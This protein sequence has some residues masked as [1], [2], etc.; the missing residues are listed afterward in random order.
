MHPSLT[1]PAIAT[2][3]ANFYGD[4]QRDPRLNPIFSATLGAHWQKHM[5]RLTDFWCTVMLG[6][7]EYRGNVYGKHMVLSGIDRDHFQRWLAL[8]ERHT[9]ALFPPEVCAEFMT[10]ARRIASSLQLGLLG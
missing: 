7:G 8:F 3:V 1:R 4:V 10:V 9:T 5:E 6:T 2:L